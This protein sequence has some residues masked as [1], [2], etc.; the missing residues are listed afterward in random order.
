LSDSVMLNDDEDNIED[1]VD[2]KTQFKVKWKKGKKSQM[3]PACLLKVS[4][5]FAK[6]VQL[7]KQIDDGQLDIGDVISLDIDGDDDLKRVSKQNP[8]Y[9]GDPQ[10]AKKKHK[11]K[12]KQ[13]SKKRKENVMEDETTS[14]LKDM[15]KE[16]SNVGNE[17]SAVVKPCTP[18][19]DKEIKLLKKEIASLRGEVVSRFEEIKTMLENLIASGG[20][21]TTRDE[22][23]GTADGRSRKMPNGVEIPL[24]TLEGANKSSLRKYVADLMLGIFTRTEMMESSLTGRAS[25]AIAGSKAKPQISRPKIAALKDLVWEMFPEATDTEI[26]SAIT[27]KLNTESKS[28]KQVVHIVAHQVQNMNFPLEQNP[29]RE[30]LAAAQN[31]NGQA[32]DE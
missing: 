12:A 9:A 24:E 4:D 22:A 32:N 1:F 10:E 25:N 13:P 2:G 27:Y 15:L 7:S 28:Q 5:D 3:V 6:L 18:A 29:K 31:T 21:D 16:N 19:I 20:L 14:Y 11:N 17:Q 23:S 8:K 30:E 26:H